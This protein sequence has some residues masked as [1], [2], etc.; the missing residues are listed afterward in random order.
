MAKEA[1]EA[2]E[3]RDA[4]KLTPYTNNRH[5]KYAKYRRIAESRG[6]HEMFNARIDAGEGIAGVLK[7]LMPDVYEVHKTRT[8]ANDF[9][10]SVHRLLELGYEPDVLVS[11]IEKQ[12]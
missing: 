6:C 9:R 8:T 3:T 12:K 11:Y 2:R 4:V 10:S 1:R 5:Y 7:D